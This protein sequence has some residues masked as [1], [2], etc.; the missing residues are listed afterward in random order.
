MANRLV[1]AAVILFCLV[2]CASKKTSAS[3]APAGA[4]SI[5]Q[6]G[7]IPDGKTKNTAAIAKAID[8]VVQRGGGVVQVPAGDFLTGPIVLKSRVRLH[9]DP[10]ALL[11]FSTEPADYPVVLTRWEGT[12]CMNYSGLISAR[13]VHDIAITGEGTIDGQGQTWWPWKSYA[14]T[15]IRKL[16][17]LGETTEDPTQ[18]IFGTVEAGLRPCLVEPINCQRILFEG[19][20]FK[21]SPFWT[22]HPI[23]CSEITARGITV[24]GDGANT[25]GL[26]PD[27][28]RDVLIENCH[29]DT[30]D[31][32]ITLKSGRDRDGRRVNKPTE[33]VTVRN[34]TFKNGHGAIT[35][36]S[37][38][39][40]GVR[41][42]LAEDCTI[43]GPDTGI[44]IKSRVG[45]GGVVENLIYRRIKVSRVNNEAITINMNYEPGSVPKDPTP[46][47]IPT[48]R[49]ITIEDFQCDD[50]KIA[51]RLLGV[52]QSPIENVTLKN[53]T[54][55]AKEGLDISHANVKTSGLVIQVNE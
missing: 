29:F 52:K 28:C 15:A 12:E 11:R 44:R 1:L 43:D 7:A 54:V 40:G 50:A 55:T 16:R 53:I 45:R 47:M 48:Y 36:G 23:Y 41:N 8:E 22:I 18:R 9:L 34:C 26:N 4:V 19:V 38:M 39:S 49:N 2:G 3:T 32:C 17:V 30:G 21:S 5:V 10:G 13:D 14:G 24:I 51:V 25:D 33:N 6:F 35:I 46:E 37:E 31:D 27:S 42:L 20:T